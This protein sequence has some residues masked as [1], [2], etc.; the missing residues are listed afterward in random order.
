MGA[1]YPFVQISNMAIF[2]IKSYYFH[3]INPTPKKKLLSRPKFQGVKGGADNPLTLLLDCKLLK[4][5]QRLQR[6]G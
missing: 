4:R 3:Y 5:M 2:A 1:Q 6:R